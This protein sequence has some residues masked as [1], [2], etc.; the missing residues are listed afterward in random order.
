M[1]VK[2]GKQEDHISAKQLI[3]TL[4]GVEVAKIIFKGDVISDEQSA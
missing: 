3:E 4:Y 2:V 1:Q